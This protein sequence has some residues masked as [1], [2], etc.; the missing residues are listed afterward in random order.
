MNS[1]RTYSLHMDNSLFTFDIIKKYLLIEKA[2]S[3]IEPSIKSPLQNYSEDVTASEI[4]KWVTFVKEKITE[5]QSKETWTCKIC[6]KSY[7]LSINSC[8]NH[9]RIT[10]KLCKML[11]NKNLKKDLRLI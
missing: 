4:V 7:S 5:L 8:S 9:P 10:K 1:D 3:Q 6:K 11:E 2:I